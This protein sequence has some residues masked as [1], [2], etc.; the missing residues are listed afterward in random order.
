MYGGSIS[1]TRCVIK[2][3]AEILF[4]LPGLIL[5]SYYRNFGRK[6]SAVDAHGPAPNLVNAAAAAPT[7]TASASNSISTFFG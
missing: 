3:G 4:Q 2:G 6:S 1:M 7:L 5:A